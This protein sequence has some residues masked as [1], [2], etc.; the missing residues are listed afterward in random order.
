[1]FYLYKLGEH[2]ATSSEAPRP[3]RPTDTSGARPWSAEECQSIHAG[4]HAVLHGAR[5]QGFEDAEGAAELFLGHAWICPPWWAAICDLMKPL[6][7]RKCSA[8]FA[9]LLPM[10]PH[11]NG[12][13]RTTLHLYLSAN[14]NLDQVRGLAVTTS[15][16]TRPGW[17]RGIPAVD[18]PSLGW[19]AFPSA[20]D[21][22]TRAETRA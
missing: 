1:M 22:K 2:G 4:Q 14:G 21:W 12:K 18:G 8:L 7:N 9:D 17:G 16:F 3:H 13:N 11:T 19:A 20:A 15:Q 5:Q 10:H 6:S